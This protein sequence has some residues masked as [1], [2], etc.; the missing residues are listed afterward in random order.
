M[1]RLK[2]AREGRRVLIDSCVWIYHFENDQRYTRAVTGVL[3]RV[4]R[5]EWAGVVS[6]ITLLEIL[7][8][9]LRKG[10]PEVADSYELLLERFPHL[11]IHPVDREVTLRAA[12][13]RARYGMRAPDALILATGLSHGADLVVTNDRAWRRVREIEVMCLK[14]PASVQNPAIEDN[15]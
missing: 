5:G 3:N 13:L 15:D 2:G 11:E 9:P 6:E 12:A 1:G 4:A 14:A 8:Q 7:T 10:Q